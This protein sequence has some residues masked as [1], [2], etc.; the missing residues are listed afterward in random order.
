MT[1]RDRDK[2]AQY[3]GNNNYGYLRPNITKVIQR[4]FYTFKEQEIKH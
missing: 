2:I 4:I 3:L 1:V